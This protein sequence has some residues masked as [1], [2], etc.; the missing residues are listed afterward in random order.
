VPF[1]NIFE[2]LREQSLCLPFM[3]EATVRSIR[4]STVLTI[5]ASNTLSLSIAQIA[6]I[7]SR[8]E[9]FLGT[10]SFQP[11]PVMQLGRTAKRHP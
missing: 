10:N 3:T 5:L 7:K 2:A 11:V 8:K 9:R 4:N 6:T 1:F